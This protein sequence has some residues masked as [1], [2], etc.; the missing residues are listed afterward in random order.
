MMNYRTQLF[1]TLLFM[2]FAGTHL[3]AQKLEELK[4]EGDGFNPSGNV[5]KSEVQFNGFTNY[6]HNTY[7]NWSSYGNLFKMATLD[8][9]KTI[10]QNKIDVAEDMGISG[11]IMQEGFIN[12]LISSPYK[13]LYQPERDALQKLVKTGNVLIYLD[14]ES[15][16]GKELTASFTGT[17]SWVKELK[18]HQYGAVDLKRIDAFVLKNGDRKIFVVSSGD[19]ETR[20]RFKALVNST[21]N[22]IKNYD[23]H[24]GWF[25][26]ETWSRSVTCTKGH[27]L[28]VIGT[29]MNEGNDW[30]VFSGLMDFTAKDDIAEWVKQVGLPV[31]T[32]VGY[33]SVFGCKNYD[34]FQAQSKERRTKK[35]W[36]DYAKK[37]DGYVFRNVWDTL[38]DPFIYDGY[39]AIEGN[40]VQI[41]NEDVPFVLR[42][43]R[44]DQN[45]TSSMVLFTKKGKE[46]TRETMWQA[47]LDRREVGILEKGK[48]MGPAKYRNAMQMLLLDRIFLDDY[49][50]TQI[51]I[52]AET[53]GYNLHVTVR[54]NSKKNVSGELEFTLPK[55]L[56]VEGKSS[57]TIK[58]NPGEK[59]TQIFALQPGAGAM[60]NTN[61]IVIKYSWDGKE[62]N[63]LSMLDLPPVISVNQLLYGHSPKVNYPVTIHNFTNKTSF[64]VKVRV[65]EP[66]NKNKVVYETTQ[67]CS[68]QKA[69]FKDMQFVLK[70]PAG[71]YNVKVSALGTETTSQLGVG[72]AEGAPYVYEIDINGDGINEYRMEN[73]SVQITL[74]A[75]G[76]RV[77]EYIVKSRND[78]I[79]FKNWPNKAIDDKRPFRERAYY[80]YGGFEDFLGQGSMENHEVYKA[81]IVKAEGD[82]VRVKMWTDYFGNKLEKIFTLYGDTPLLEIRFALTFKNPE[83]NVLGPQPI[84]AL[85]EKHWTEDLFII[86]ELDGQKEI[87]MITDDAFGHLSFIKEGWNA[88]YDTE[89][90]ITFV[91]A[92][93]V[94]Q[95][96]FLHIWM[97]H[98][99]N[100]DTHFYY[101]E[102]QPWVPIFQK[103]TMYFT[104][105]LW[106]AGGP[107]KNGV[108]DLREMNLITVR[109]K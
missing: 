66:D 51:N 87:K 59:S 16:L 105:Y 61:P 85:G 70:I 3:W 55:A 54:N 29:G 89:K 11:L 42:T 90:D 32:D 43:G 24:K 17:D 74:L 60:N 34:G 26:V 93:P 31:V 4:Y 49:F 88:G 68:T 82:F 38:A 106:G 41:D 8:V 57:V 81:E 19:T 15:L 20:D 18:S 40:K 92:F 96:L 9:G 30:F 53:E 69:T 6:W 28:E 101:A 103:S 95:P 80:P 52:V 72:K 50:G 109:K 79:L 75:T 108:K 46:F 7:T 23:F 22:V 13:V 2:L 84:L 98:P 27:P 107:W 47:I 78:N 48:M 35:F 104:Y 77:I 12:D 99:K 37:K 64:P 5:V 33:S 97:N 65:V 25:G 63:V 44:L 83:A 94:E 14:P 39:F 56:K 58:L 71:N 1:V 76:A 102:F 73:D 100:H 45:A 62:K 67:T 36:V 91:G 10:L 86:P 21:E